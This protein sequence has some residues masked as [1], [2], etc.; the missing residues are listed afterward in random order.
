VGAGDAGV[1]MGI[2]NVTP[3]SFSDGGSYI[4]PEIAVQHAREMIEAGA[5]IIDVG[6]ESTRP[7]AA[8][9]SVEEE[10]RRVLPVIGALREHCPDCVI[11]VDTSKAAVAF[12]ACQA[13]ASIVNDVT[14]LRG[15]A[16]MAAVVADCGAGLV[17]MHMQGT[18]RTMQKAPVYGDV[19]EE[20]VDFLDGQRELALAEGVGDE[21]IVFD[22]GIGFGKSEEHNWQ[23]LNRVGE[24]D[25]LLRPLLLGVSR[26]GFIGAALDR[27]EAAGRAVGTAALTALLRARGVRLHRVH[28]VQENVDALRIAESL[29]RAGGT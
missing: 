21:A 17:L 9:V 20:V 10:A 7:G 26:K 14:A 23:L 4:E 6:G 13:G 18:P 29:I 12:E 27:P 25:A 5:K 15:D 1:V 16:E 22:P 28:D 8:E 3:D 24:F 2:L 19:V 11:S